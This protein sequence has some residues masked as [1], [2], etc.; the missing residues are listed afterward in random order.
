M[1]DETCTENARGAGVATAT[2]R[3]GA[4]P[5]DRGLGAAAA[6]AAQGDQVAARHVAHRPLR[7]V[8]HRATQRPVVLRG[9]ADCV[10]KFGVQ[11]PALGPP[12]VQLP[13]AARA[14]RGCQMRICFGQSAGLY[15]FSRLPCLQQPEWSAAH[16]LSVATA[17]GNCVGK[18]MG[19]HG[20]D[21]TCTTLP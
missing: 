16:Q 15:I 14:A 9:R 2:S 12:G 21:I 5:E 11:G 19:R 3:K 10:L 8:L 1:C 13:C 6:V 4:A 20:A 7:A 17:C 18:G